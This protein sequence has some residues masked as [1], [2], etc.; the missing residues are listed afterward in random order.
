MHSDGHF[1]KSSCSLL[2]FR[3]SDIYYTEPFSQTLTE[4]FVVIS[5]LSGFHYL[6]SPLSSVLFNSVNFYVYKHC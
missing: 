1:G 5:G 4:H 3:S 2:P 6:L